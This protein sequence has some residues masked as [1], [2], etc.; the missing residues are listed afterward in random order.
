MEYNIIY[1]VCVLI[2]GPHSAQLYSRH[3]VY[4]SARNGKIN[5]SKSDTYS[6]NYVST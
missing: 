1:D 5:F 3:V 2:G 6:K 4:E